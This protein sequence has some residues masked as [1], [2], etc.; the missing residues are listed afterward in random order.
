MASKF[1]GWG[2]SWGG[3]WGPI[4]TVYGDPI[5]NPLQVALQ[6]VGFSVLSVALQGFVAADQVTPPPQQTYYTAGLSAIQALKRQQLE[7]DDVLLVLLQQFVME[8]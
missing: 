1:T 6:G 2:S 4:A 5:V 7:E 8:A 3:S